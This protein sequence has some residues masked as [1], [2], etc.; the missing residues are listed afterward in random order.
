VDGEEIELNLCGE[1]KRHGKQITIFGEA[2]TRIYRREVKDFVNTVKSLSITGEVF[3]VMFGFLV[4]PS[5]S[6]VAE[7]DVLLVA[8]YQR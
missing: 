5:G 3:K 1:G 6:E 7:E 4:H 8:S 2:K